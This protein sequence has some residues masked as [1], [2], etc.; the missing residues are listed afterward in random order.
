MHSPRVTVLGLFLAVV[1]TAVLGGAG[2]LSAQR[3]LPIGGEGPSLQVQIV[4]PFPSDDGPFAGASFS[5]SGWDASVAYPLA[6]G[7]TL[8]ARM[9]LVYASI[10]GVDGSLAISSPRLGVLL[11]SDMGGRSAEVHVDLPTAT[12]VGETYA[13]GIA[14]FSAY[15]EKE[16]FLE[17]TWSVGASATAEMEPGPGAFV[18]ARAGTSVL[19]PTEGSTDVYALISLFGHAPTDETRFRIEFS[20]LA[21]LS[22]SDVDF[23]DRTTFF[24]SLDITWPSVRFAPTLFVRAPIDNTL[25]ATVPIVA[26]ARVLFGG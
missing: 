2:S 15:D 12:D 21:L 23:S 18:G 6:S 8:F 11:G 4:K 22:G 10:E 17:D 13:T 14:I 19:V 9:G 16:R 1:F 24:A 20:S 3:Y 7:P 26:G 25:D 5:T